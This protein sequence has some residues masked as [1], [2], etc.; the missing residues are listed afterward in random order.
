[1]IKQHE[2]GRSGSASSA[3]STDTV[4][5]PPGQSQQQKQQQQARKRRDSFVMTFTDADNMLNPNE[6]LRLDSN[7]AN[8]SDAS[9]AYSDV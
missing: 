5:E 1:M 2:R 9:A 6:Y 8:L 7:S 3:A 4:R